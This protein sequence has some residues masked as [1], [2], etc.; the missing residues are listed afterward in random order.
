VEHTLHDPVR[1]FRQPG[2]A[3]EEAAYV[4]CLHEVHVRRTSPLIEPIPTATVLCS[5]CVD[6]YVPDGNRIPRVN[7]LSLLVA[8]LV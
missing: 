7:G 6:D 3:G 4:C 8:R 2:I 1:V 5:R